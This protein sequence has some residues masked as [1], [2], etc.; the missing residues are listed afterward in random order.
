[1]V[2]HRGGEEEPSGSRPASLP[3][4]DAPRATA[5]RPPP[6]GA[7]L[8][9]V[10]DIGRPNDKE[11]CLTLGPR[12]LYKGW[13]EVETI[14]RDNLMRL[15]KRFI[16]EQ[17]WKNASKAATQLL[18]MVEKDLSE[19]KRKRNSYRNDLSF[20]SR[21][22]ISDVVRV[23]YEIALNFPDNFP[24]SRLSKLTRQLYQLIPSSQRDARNRVI[25]NL[26]DLNLVQGD[27]RRTHVEIEQ[28]GGGE[29]V[30]IQQ[31][32]LLGLVR[33]EEWWA[34]ADAE[35]GSGIL[36]DLAAVRL[37]EKA[38]YDQL[39]SS[40][41]G[42]FHDAKTKLWAIFEC[43]CPMGQMEADV[44][45]RL[46]VLHVAEG[47]VDDFHEALQ[48]RRMKQNKRKCFNPQLAKV[49]LLVCLLRGDENVFGA[50]LQVS[51]DLPSSGIPLQALRVV[52]RRVESNSLGL[53]KESLTEWRSRIHLEGA[54]MAFAHLDVRDTCVEAWRILAGFLDAVKRHDAEAVDFR[55]AE[56]IPQ[57]EAEA[58]LEE[59]W[60]EREGWWDRCHFN[61]QVAVRE[62]RPGDKE[63][64]ERMWCQ[65]ICALYLGSRAAEGLRSAVHSRVRA[66]PASLRDVKDR[67]ELY[68]EASWLREDGAREDLGPRPAP[69]R[70]QVT[71]IIDFA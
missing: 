64:A 4:R 53:S 12:R 33:Y 13:K 20:S 8:C 57:A 52:R 35:V 36:Q 17:D 28:L 37:S 34:Y 61:P 24:F 41:K 65:L 50:M 16:R 19:K 68:F 42:A 56:G 60:R 23:F 9:P 30:N 69:L 3:A 67:A 55:R 27:P 18:R 39:S 43:D 21:E 40:A 66:C 25:D 51:A 14:H 47:T 1:M 22:T 31:C 71:C 38:I 45:G 7:L 29:A 58:D 46:L 49:D 48:D 32:L 59:L 5:S 62:G 44:L 2:V 54:R 63:T 11:S 6:I 26:V 70:Q 10:F 15:A